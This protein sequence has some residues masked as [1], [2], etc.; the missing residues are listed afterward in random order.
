MLVSRL[1]DKKPDKTETDHAALEKRV[2]MPAVLNGVSDMV[3]RIDEALIG[4]GISLPFGG[5]LI[6]IA[7]KNCTGGSRS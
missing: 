7:T 3:M 6:V 5:S 2:K 1:L 4:W